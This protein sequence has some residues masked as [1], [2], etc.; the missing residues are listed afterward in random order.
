MITSNATANPVLAA[1]LQK[2]YLDA[3]GYVGKRVAP[4]FPT[5]LQSASYY[6]F[7]KEN[8]LSIP[9]D[10]SR[11]PS[12]PFKR[13][14]LKISDTN[15]SCQEKGIE[16]P[17]DDT[18]RA[19]YAIAFAAD[20]AAMRRA[21]LVITSRHEIRVAR[22]ATDT[23]QVNNTSPD[24]PWSAYNDAD[25]NPVGDVDQAKES[26][27]L[28]C[29]LQAN[30]MVLPQPVFNVLKEHPTILDKIKYSE[31]G[32]VT[33]EIL[34]EVFGVQEIVIPGAVING[35]ADGQIVSPQYIWGN[36]VWLGH[37]DGAV[38]L[39]APNFARTFVWSQFSGADGMSVES[40]RE[41]QTKS[42]VHRAQQHS[43]ERVTGKELAFLL[44]DVIE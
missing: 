18:E 34:A 23:A 8:L 13:T 17:V 27:K 12:M 24:V 2:Y 36:K 1:T 43:D 39:Q 5:S 20:E 14:Q 44:T 30:L 31:R 7:D 16:C 9:A 15:Y 10:I 11:A 25:S 40:Y 32:V 4:L 22:M 42:D 37:V 41:E 21:A 3:N 28:G 29:G 26:I 35:A 6:V 33:A 19:K 38:D